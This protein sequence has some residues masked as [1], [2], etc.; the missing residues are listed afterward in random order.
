M[1]FTFSSK[2]YLREES[3]M[4]GIKT[5]A[6]IVLVALLGAGLAVAMQHEATVDMGKALFNDPKLGTTGK[7]C[8]DCHP[9]GKGVE[10]AVGKKDLET[11]LNACIT[12]GLKGKAL[13]VKSMEM[14]SLMLYVN[15]FG[16]KKTE[17]K[18]AP[19]GC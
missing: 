16:E 14:Q 5:V 17:T 11:I 2:L 4:N 1:I 3:G 18:K 13:D 19:V 15:S 6:F 9:N 10:K 8:N 12:K 7:T